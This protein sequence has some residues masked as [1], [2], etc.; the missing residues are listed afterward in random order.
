[1]PHLTIEYSANV[2]DHHD[3]DA[4]LD[5]VHQAALDHGLAPLAGLRTRAVARE[6][7]RV[8]DGGADLAFIAITARM[9]PG[10]DAATKRSFIEYVLDQ[11]CRQV[12]GEA[13]EPA[14]AWSIEI[15]ELDADFR[16]N[17]NRV[18][19]RLQQRAGNSSPETPTGSP[20]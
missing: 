18:K 11:A 14:I 13:R 20:T 5:V 16:I 19:D 1:M 15:Q 8:A 3:I 2:A 10:R 9:A 4:L 17:R 12:E 7:Y 6:D